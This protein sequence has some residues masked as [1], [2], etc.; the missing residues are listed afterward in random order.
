MDPE[1]EALLGDSVGLALLVVLDSL[2]PAERVAFVLHDVFA[3]P[4]DEI[5]P[6]VGRTPTATGSS[7]AVPAAGCRAR[8][9][10]TSTWMVSGRS[11]THSWR[12]RA[13]VTSNASSPSSTRMSWYVPKAGR[14]GRMWSPGSVARRRSPS[15]R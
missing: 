5:A 13:T 6:I 1:Q 15:R 11:S 12:R 2:T 9:C 3:V 4:F 8:P 10:P 14:R 7:R